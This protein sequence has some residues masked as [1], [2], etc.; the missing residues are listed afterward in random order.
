[1]VIFRRVVAFIAGI[2][3]GAAGEA[4]P[5]VGFGVVGAAAA[6]GEFLAGD[7]AEVFAGLGRAREG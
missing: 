5:A 4:E 3:F 1:M 2:H 7:D 6:A